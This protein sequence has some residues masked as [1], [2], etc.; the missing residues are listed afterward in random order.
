MSEFIGKTVI[1]TLWQC[2]YEQVKRLKS[3]NIVILLYDMHCVLHIRTRNY[4]IITFSSKLS[5][6]EE[7][8]CST[9]FS[10]RILSKN[11]LELVSARHYIDVDQFY[12]I[13]VRINKRQV[14]VPHTIR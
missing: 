13:T 6:N 3:V 7:E 14:H 4:M 8:I 10:V 12:R 11:I 9:Y 5:P 1:A 2:N